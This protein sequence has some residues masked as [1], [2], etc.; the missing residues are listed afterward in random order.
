MIEF[1][2]RMQTFH[3][4]NGQISYL[5]KI[6]DHQYLS[7]LYFGPAVKDYSGHFSY[8][9]QAR[10]F[11]PSPAAYP[12]HDFSLDTVMLEYPAGNDDFR[13]PAITLRHPDGSRVS[14]FRYDSYQIT[15]GKPD[16]A[17]LPH[18][19]VTDDNDCE[20]LCLTLKD[21]LSGLRLHLFY[22]I[23]AQQDVISRHVVLHNDGANTC[24]IEK[25]ASLNLDFP[26]QPMD[27]I[28]LP[29]GWAK[30][31]MVVRE[32][33]T[34][35]I[36]L[37][38][39]KRGA[40]SSQ[41]NPAVI[42]TAKET[43][44]T[45]GD[46]Y[47]LTLVYSGNHEITVEKD[48]YDQT[49]ATIGINSFGF[50]WQLA[51]GASFTAPEALLAYSDQGLNGLSRQFHQVINQHLIPQRYQKMDRPILV[52]N[53][54]GTYFDF[55]DE[56]ILAI[57]K[58][59]Q[60]LGIE[61]FVLDDGW[62]GHRDSDNSSLGDW[63]EYPGKLKNGLVAL[64]QE[65]KA[66]GLQFGLWFEPEMISEDSELFRAHP[67]WRLQVPGRQ[68]A[69][70][71]QQFVLDFSRQEVRDEIFRQMTAVLDQL[72]IDYI[73]WDMNRN[74]TDVFSAVLPANQQGEVAHRYIL[75]LYELIDRLTKRYPTI[76][77]ESCSGG[78]AR[79]DCG[80]LYYMPQTWTS[81]DTDAGERMKIQYGTSLIYPQSTMGAHV[82]AVP[83][84]QVGRNTSLLTRGNVAMGGLL[85]YEL[86][87]TQLSTE[88]KS[89][90][91]E[92][93]AFYKEHRQL[94]QYG[95]FYRLV[96]PF[97]DN[98]VAWQFISRDQ[99]ESIVFFA[100]QYA[101]PNPPLRVLKLQGLNPDLTYQINDQEIAGDELMQIGF[102]LPIDLHGDF[103]SRLVVLKAK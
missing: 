80:L 5:L 30:E 40:S 70:G 52:N 19:Y 41:Q 6:E 23:F 15:K 93:V 7:H 48:Q 17:G 97:D 51:P 77:F 20:T 55:N 96:S 99:K 83:N 63:F 59:A 35:G 65:I 37:L 34:T 13:V 60:A 67:D 75:G 100:Q 9:R 47:G 36:K 58:E 87:L 102:Y 66:L 50:D 31:R 78:G 24:T 95:D 53:W 62:F 76:L 49:R 39:S 1:S 92:Q 26:N 72:P 28:H 64:A 10:S 68:P 3:L 46:A 54:E 33:V 45:L 98:L 11:S 73:K 88:E 74:M 61:M 85:G 86:D 57:A 69:S 94:L 91:K 103:D 8:P 12:R 27:L 32:P 16:L 43:T 82:S 38:D 56:K 101:Q 84:H 29:G 89:E 79:F 90:I 81:D 21:A 4:T 14:D 71:R 18:T 22:T 44:E 2:Q 25:I 42:L